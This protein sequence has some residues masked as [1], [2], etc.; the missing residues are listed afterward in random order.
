VNGSSQVF[1][2]IRYPV[3][4]TLP[5]ESFLYYKDVNL[6]FAKASESSQLFSSQ[7]PSGTRLRIDLYLHWIMT[8]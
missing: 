6:E 5:V 4:R 3:R 8:L 7:S 1:L 2:D